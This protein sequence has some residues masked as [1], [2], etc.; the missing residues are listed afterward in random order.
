[1]NTRVYPRSRLPHGAS[2]PRAGSSA[3]VQVVLAW[4]VALAACGPALRQSET[5]TPDRVK[6]VT[7]DDECGLQGYFDGR[8][9]EYQQKSDFNVGAEGHRT[10]G[11]VEYTLS[12]GVQAK[13]FVE[14][15]GRL[16][17]RVPQ[18]SAEEPL[19]V[20][21]A[22]QQAEG[23]RSLPINADTTVEQG[24][25]AERLELPYHP[26]IGA[27][28]FGAEQYAMRRSLAEQ[29]RWEQTNVALPK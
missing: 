26:C 4:A 9:G 28:F 10:A 19:T 7:F 27:F 16:Y 12:P 18:L 21:I 15:V 20:T 8:P 1:M 6:A 24:S 14:L 25:S 17:E 2:S 11:S 22:Y 29:K 13:T 5:F 23:R 3:R